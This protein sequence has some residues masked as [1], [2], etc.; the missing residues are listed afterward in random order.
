M[1]KDKIV[2]VNDSDGYLDS[3]GN[4]IFQNRF[5]KFRCISYAR[6]IGYTIYGI[7]IRIYES[8]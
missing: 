2:I 3:R 7:R 1:Q 4:C 5:Y 8:E 6:Y